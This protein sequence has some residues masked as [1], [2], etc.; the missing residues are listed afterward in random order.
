MDGEARVRQTGA[1]ALERGQRALA[2]RLPERL[3]NRVLRGQRV[4][5]RRGRAVTD[6]RTAVEPGERL[7]AARPAKPNQGEQGGSRKA[8]END[9]TDGTGDRGQR[10]PESGPGHHQKQADDSENTRQTGPGTLP[11]DGISGP[12]EGLRQLQPRQSIA[13]ADRV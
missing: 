3:R 13:I 5:E 11:R 2:L 9:E 10:Q 6:A 7:F 1:D 8:R 12:L 4:R